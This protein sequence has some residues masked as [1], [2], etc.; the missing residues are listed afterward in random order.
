M[1]TG[2]IK[3][4][5][6][7]KNVTP[8]SGGLTVRIKQPSS[9]KLTIGE[10]IA[11]EGICSTVIKKGKGWFEIQYMSE[12]LKKT[13]AADFEAGRRVNLEQSLR[14]NDLVHGHLVSGHV[15]TRGSVK[16]VK[17]TDGANELRISIPKNFMKYVAPKGSI[18]INGVALSVVDA[19]ASWF[20]VAL[21]PYT[22]KETTL[23]LLRA[24]SEVNVETDMLAKY[25]YR[26][27][28]H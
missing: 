15:D 5:A 2:I 6:E 8:R 1:F 10:S 24:G 22:L 27:L 7:I 11:V 28:T 23:S 9:Y 25:V 13:I 16:D 4:T 26:I 17:K 20:S 19:H 14:L 12:T 3:K 21:T 18:A